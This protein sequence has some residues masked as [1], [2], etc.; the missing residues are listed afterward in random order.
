M[1]LYCVCVYCLKSSFNKSYLT[2]NWEAN[3][4]WKLNVTS[5]QAADLL[6]L[7]IYL[8]DMWKWINMNVFTYIK[9]R[10]CPCLDNVLGLFVFFT[11]ISECSTYKF[12]LIFAF[13]YLSTP[14]HSI[15][16]FMPKTSCLF[17]GITH[18]NELF[19]LTSIMQLDACT[20]S[21]TY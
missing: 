3:L 7:F 8:V 15:H 10:H 6:F 20:C 18:K 21:T 2:E 11:C 19:P 17:P 14:A 13:V 12:T 5:K 16:P 9:C 1:F 4:L